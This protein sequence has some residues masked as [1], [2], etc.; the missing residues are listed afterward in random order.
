M[1]KYNSPA[2]MYRALDESAKRAATKRSWW[3]QISRRRWYGEWCGI[4][5]TQR[6]IMLSLWLSAGKKGYSYPSIRTLA[7]NLEISRDAVGRNI[8]ELEKKGFFKI[9]KTITQRGRANRYILL[10]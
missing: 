1:P 2:E 7:R 3:F 8:L 9:E 5:P 6:V 4:N 10:K